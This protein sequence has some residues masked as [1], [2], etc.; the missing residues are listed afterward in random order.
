[1]SFF[2]PRGSAHLPFA[3]IPPFDSIFGRALVTTLPS[4]YLPS[5]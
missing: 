1:M 2:F 5:S 3:P 4:I